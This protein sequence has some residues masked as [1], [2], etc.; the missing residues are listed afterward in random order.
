MN[1]LPRLSKTKP[2]FSDAIGWMLTSNIPSRV[3]IASGRRLLLFAV[4]HLIPRKRNLEFMVTDMISALDE[5]Q[6]KQPGLLIATPDL[7]QGGCGITLLNQ[8]HQIQSSLRSILIVDPI[9]DNIMSAYQSSATG[10]IAEQEIFAAGNHQD[11][12]IMTLA[13]DK[14]YRSPLLKASWANHKGLSG[15]SAARS[16]LP[17]NITARERDVAE[18]LIRGCTERTASEHL[19]IGYNTVR[20]H[21]QS[22]RR[23]LGV[24][25]RNQ[26]LVKLLSYDLE[27]HGQM[28]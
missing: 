16:Q 1:I 13:R 10:V 22:L 21:A 19:G 6:E 14:T 5:L 26:L 3:G 9:R 25:N 4:Y 24:S 12:L 2:Y 20:S 17:F 18:L 8:A 11:D 23:K 7:E 15:S 27:G 28:P